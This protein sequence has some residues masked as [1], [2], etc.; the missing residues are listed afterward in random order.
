M[1]SVFE[2]KLRRSLYLPESLKMLEFFNYD[3]IFY[4]FP[5]LLI[6]SGIQAYKF[7]ILCNIKKS[8]KLKDFFIENNYIIKYP[9]YKNGYFAI[10]KKI[11]FKILED[12]HPVKNLYKY[13]DFRLEEIYFTNKLFIKHKKE[14]YTMKEIVIVYNNNVDQIVKKIKKYNEINYS[15]IL[16]NKDNNFIYIYKSSNSGAFINI[17]NII[18]YICNR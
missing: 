6:N 9:K 16:K 4:G 15:F 14:F 10:R 5:L 17:K 7:K 13:I 2:K 8:R 11:R 18:V 12:Q 1:S 3:C